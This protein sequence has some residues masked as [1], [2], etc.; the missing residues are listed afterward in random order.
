MSERRGKE[1]GGEKERLRYRGENRGR[2]EERE[3]YL[4]DGL[5]IWQF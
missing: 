5:K 1:G 2:E 4:I 3:H